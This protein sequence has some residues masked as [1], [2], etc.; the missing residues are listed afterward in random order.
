M[1]PEPKK[2]MQMMPMIN[3][4]FSHI[5]YL[6]PSPISITPLQLDTIF[7]SMYGMKTCAPVVHLVHQS[8]ASQL[9][10]S[11][12]T[13][14]AGLINGMYKPRWD[15]LAN[16]FTTEYNPIK[17][18]SDTFHEEIEETISSEKSR[19]PN[20]TEETTST[21]DN[22]TVVSDG[23]TEQR[24]TNK[25]NE[26]TRTN[27]LSEEVH[28]TNQNDVYG[29]NSGQAVGYDAGA[30]DTTRA[31]TGTVGDSGSSEEETTINGGLTH[32]TDGTI[33]TTGTKRTTGSDTEQNSTDRNRV[34]DLTHLG[35]IGNITTQ[36]LLTQEIEL[37]RWNFIKEVLSDVKDF[38][39]LPVYD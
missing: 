36:Q 39:T 4:I 30:N 14:L 15:K 23:G 35:N 5:N 9:T 18:Y 17:N 33:S 10:D 2:V 28:G 34:R 38:L 1:L 13:T 37:W 29:F 27:D 21:E 11:E 32:T 12:L 31:N 3:G 8:E 7:L 20:L 6:F 24:L 22:D 16:V 26:N 25:T 19:T